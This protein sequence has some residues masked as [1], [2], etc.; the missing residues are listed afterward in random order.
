MQKFHIKN[1]KVVE[2]SGVILLPFPP[3]NDIIRYIHI[4]N[5]GKYTHGAKFIE[6]IQWL[7]ST[8]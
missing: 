6:H 3:E 2:F 7:G 5:V 1:Q 8:E 4:I